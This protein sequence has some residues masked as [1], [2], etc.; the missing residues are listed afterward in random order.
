M[1]EY[2]VTW[3]NILHPAGKPRTSVVRWDPTGTR[4]LEAALSDKHN[5]AGPGVVLII[6]SHEV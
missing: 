2:R 5:L 6:E 1:R 3:L 4:S